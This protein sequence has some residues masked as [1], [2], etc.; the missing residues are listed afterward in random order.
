MT[1]IAG[2]ILVAELMIREALIYIVVALAPR[3]F[4]TRVWPVTKSATRK[5]LEVLWAL[6]CSKL[7]IAVALAVAAAAAV[8]SGSGGEVTSLPPPEVFAENPGG[9]VTQAVGILLMAAA[10][11]GV[12]AFSPLLIGRLLPIREA[13]VVAQNVRWVLL[14]G[15]PQRRMPG[16]GHRARA[17]T[18]TGASCPRLRSRR[19]GRAAAER[20]T[21]L[22]GAQERRPVNLVLP[23]DLPNDAFVHSSKWP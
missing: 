22:L 1:D 21:A 23:A 2:I 18:T 4:A 16:P 7:V 17:I 3:V 15:R 9:S 8:G 5:L 6:I 10:A 13:A 14:G 19:C 20:L 11:F 12:A